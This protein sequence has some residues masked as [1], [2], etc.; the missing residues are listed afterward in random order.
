MAVIN[1]LTLGEDEDHWFSCA[2]AQVLLFRDVHFA[3]A[4]NYCKATSATGLRLIITPKLYKHNSYVMI[5]MSYRGANN[6]LFAADY[7]LHKDG[8]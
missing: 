6:A 2:S 3:E 5:N 1:R 4:D 8:T 7:D